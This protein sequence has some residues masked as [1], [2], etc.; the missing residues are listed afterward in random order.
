MGNFQDALTYY[1]QAYEIRDKLRLTDGV[2]ESL[3]NLAETNVALGQYET[4]VNQF[5]KALDISRNGGDMDGVALNSVSLG[6]LYSAQGQYGSAIS[7]FQESLKDFNQANDTTWVVVETKARYGDVLSAVGNWTEGQPM[8][9][10]AVKQAADV[11]NDEV[12]ARALN[13][14]GD[15][16]FYRGDYGNARQQYDRASQVATKAKNREL[17]AISQFNQA[18]LDVEQNRA[19]AAVPVLKKMIEESD[20][21]GLKAMSVQASVWLAQALIATNKPEEA[22]QE[23]DRALNRAEKL[24]LRVEV[25]RAHYLLGEIY[26]TT[27][28]TREYAPQYQEAVRIL[29]S[30]S[31]EQGAGRL[32]DRSDLKNVYHEAMKSY[33][34]GE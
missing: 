21:L 7:A 27:G 15:S 5:L 11:K 9:E 32:L 18:R 6:E 25:A 31:K 17:I 20:S 24:G 16:Y 34:G 33:Q 4:A 22:Q 26:S 10:E 2:A 3:H 14:L 13:L 29:Q 30:I 23:L 28:R 8:L 1:Q 12:L 19:V